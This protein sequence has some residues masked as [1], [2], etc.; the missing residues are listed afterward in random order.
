[1]AGAGTLGIATAIRD[2]VGGDFLGV[3]ALVAIY[4]AA[5]AVDVVNDY[6]GSLSVQAAARRQARQRRCLRFQSLHLTVSD[7]SCLRPAA[8]NLLPKAGRRV[9]RD[10]A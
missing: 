3:I 1:V 10:W 8:P 6:A 7:H 4:L 9:H 5:V 2:L